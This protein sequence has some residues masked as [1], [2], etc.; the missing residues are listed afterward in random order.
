MKTKI[1]NL[2]AGPGSGKSTSAAYLFYVLK[3]RGANAELVREYVKEWAWDQRTI[4][5][6]DQLYF[7]GKQGRK[8]SM[9][10]G[11][12]DHIITDSPCLMAAFYAKKHCPPGF[13]EGIRNVAL[14][15]YNQAIE[16]G[17]EHTHVFVK[18]SKGYNPAGRF[19]TEEQAKDID[20]ELRSF[21]DALKIP[22]TECGT[23]RADL[24]SLIG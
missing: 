1:I 23:D 20:G 16:E 3:T 24:E 21:L 14:S 15:F 8:E 2:Y 12:V 11:K 6:Y 19:Q 9:L 17:H 18:R 10:Y 5:T 13:A 4:S 7:L 22:Y